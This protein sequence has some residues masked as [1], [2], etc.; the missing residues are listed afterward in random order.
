MGTGISGL[1]RSYRSLW[2]VFRYVFAD[3]AKFFRHILEP[4]DSDFFLQYA[5]NELQN[6]SHKWLLNLNI[7]RKKKFVVS[8]NPT[9]P[10]FYPPTLK[11]LWT[12]LC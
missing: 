9:D 12:Y 5:L 7:R 11:I 4:Q 8:G 3:D 1:M 6:W 10:S 2:T